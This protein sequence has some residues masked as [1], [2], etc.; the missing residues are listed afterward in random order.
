VKLVADE[1]VDRQIVDRLRFDGHD[2]VYIA[3]LAS[4][5]DDETVLRKGRDSNAVLLR[6]TKIS[7]S[8]FSAR[9]CFTRE[10]YSSGSG[11]SRP[12]AKPNL[13]RGLLHNMPT[14]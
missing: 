3:E 7:A 12:I 11:V 6:P 2:F 4:G 1:S 9:V 10:S 8:S 14:I 13:S 5:V